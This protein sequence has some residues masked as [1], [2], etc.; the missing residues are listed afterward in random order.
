MLIRVASLLTLTSRPECTQLGPW[1]KILPGHRWS[2]KLHPGPVAGHVCDE[3]TAG[4]PGDGEI[5]VQRQVAIKVSNKCHSEICGKSAVP[6][7][8]QLVS[9]YPTRSVQGNRWECALSCEKL[10]KSLSRAVDTYL[11]YE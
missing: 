8:R 6:S 5:Q 10:M 2:P 9:S 1:Q 11:E 4:Q 3:Q 7:E